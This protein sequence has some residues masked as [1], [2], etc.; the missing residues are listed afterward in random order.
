MMLGIK[1]SDAGMP[2]PGIYFQWGDFLI[3]FGNLM[4]IA[5]MVA[6]FVLALV[7]PFP[8]RRSRK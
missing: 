8:G 2:D 5:I 6:L 4:V 3:Q 1:Q 7:V